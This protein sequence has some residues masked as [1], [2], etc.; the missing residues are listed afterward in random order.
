[1][2]RKNANKKLEIEEGGLSVNQFTAQTN[3][4]KDL[5]D[6]ANAELRESVDSLREYKAERTDLM[7]RVEKQ[8]REIE[9]LKSSDESK[10]EE[11][12]DTRAKL[13]KLRALFETYVERTGI[14]MTPE[15][16]S[17]FEDTL[18]KELFR[19]RYNQGRGETA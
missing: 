3:A 13:E 1:L 8:G 15:E 14:P 18:P 17:I 2:N 19:K 5:L 12:S 10:S 7:A 11:L 6:R 4:Y 16:K 9:Y